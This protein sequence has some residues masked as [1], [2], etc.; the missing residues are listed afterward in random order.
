M[1]NTS[2]VLTH[3]LHQELSSVRVAVA[4]ADLNEAAD[5]RALI[6]ESRSV[7]NDA[8]L[9]APLR[10]RAGVSLIIAA[11]L[12]LDSALA[13]NCWQELNKLGKALGAEHTQVL[14][15]KLIFHTVFG[16]RRIAVRT[17]RSILR[18]HPLPRIDV[19]AVIAR[20]NALFALQIL[21]EAVAFRPTASATYALM[22][23]R[24][25][26]TEAVYVAVT[27]AEDALALGD[28]RTALDWLSRA[29][30]VVSR[31]HET[32]EGVIQG[33]L[34]ALSNVAVHVGE[35]STAKRLLIQVHKR[36]RL[37]ATPRLRAINAAYLIRLSG[38]EGLQLPTGCDLD[39]LRKD[40]EAGCRLGRQD[41]V[42]E[43]L[44]LAY[45]LI[46]SAEAAN[47]LL[48]EY[49]TKH[50]REECPSEWS[51]WNS[52]RTDPFWEANRSLIPSTRQDPG[53]SV[54]ALQ[55]IIASCDALT[56]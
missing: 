31:V 47:A 13:I 48:D 37:V 3:P 25:I 28:F 44:W 22:L 11:D 52:T 39:Q 20:R 55:T 6:N 10:M 43:G 2:T 38:L 29:S 51:L 4:E 45:S 16:N 5:L 49:F 15:A 36:L 34:S 46:G 9:E 56:C 7:I 33:Y 50:R 23:E 17:A 41:T 27:L 8:T 14:R 12:G 54:R 21:G 18:L 1:E 32:A 53:A 26:Y 30:E 40:Y 42:V 24:K 35:Y 19:A